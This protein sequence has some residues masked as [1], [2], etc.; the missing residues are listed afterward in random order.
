MTGL[1]ARTRRLLAPDARADPDLLT[2]LGRTSDIAAAREAGR[3]LAGIPGRRVTGRELRPLRV[4]VATTFTCDAVP[5]FLTIAL[6]ASGIDAEVHLTAPDQFLVELNDPSSGLA[7]FRPDVTLCLLDE[8]MFWPSELDGTDLP[9]LREEL[10]RRRDALAAA[11]RALQ[12]RSAAQVLV[13][14][15]PLPQI[16][17]R[18]I[19]A[20]RSRA[21]LAR[22]W[23]ELNI[24]LLDLAEHI[25]G[26]HVLE[27][28]ALLVEHAGP[29]RDARRHRFAAMSW[30]PSAQRLYATEAARFCRAA[31]GMSAKCLVLDLD[32]TLWGGVLGDDGPEHL[33]VGTLYPGNAYL[34]TQRTALALRRQG[35]LLA[36]SSKN[37]P[38][39]VERVFAEHPGLA[40]RT[41]DFSTTAVNWLSKDGNVAAIAEELGIGLDSIVFADDSRF[42]CELVAGFL[43]SVNVVHLAGDP[44]E[45]AGRLVTEG[46]FDVLST[47]DTDRQRPELY[48]AR[49]ERQRHRAEHPASA[50]EYL[51]TIGL[52]VSVR[53]ADAFMLPRIRQ[54]RLRTNQFTLLGPGAG[55]PDTEAADGTRDRRVLGFEATDRFGDEGLVGA[56]WLAG[57]GRRWLIE[58]FV[59]SCRVFSRGIEFAVLQ[60]VIDR[61]VAASAVRLDASFRSTGRNGAA[62]AFLDEAGFAPTGAAEGVAR[63]T[64]PLVPA[65]SPCPDWITLRKVDDYVSR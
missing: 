45:H 21:A 61:A 13:H 14:T 26:V 38:D 30:S 60:D 39:L 46:H 31:A 47:T 1:L 42:E 25:D 6:L 34:E 41:A 52:S 11:L 49:A 51:R 2:E 3:L 44:A 40:L 20:Y 62:K 15:V 65:P 50:A 54:L 58:N 32:N 19:V 28:E 35:V 59:M 7:R 5:A 4:A 9:A 17:L 22:L 64:L 29:F 57:D 24:D 16:R 27:W 53:T 23:R 48:R 37:D 8:A 33:D 12:A 36:I 56:V 43:P 10:H 18:S 63:Y 55:P